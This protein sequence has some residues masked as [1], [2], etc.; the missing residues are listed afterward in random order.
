MEEN[1]IYKGEII[2]QENMGLGIAIINGMTVFVNNGL[3]GDMGD[4]MITSIKKNYAIGKMIDFDKKSLDRVNPICNNFNVC[5][6]CDLMHQ[7]YKSQLLFKQT[8]VIDIIKRIAKLDNIRVNNIIGM[9]DPYNYRNKV[10]YHVNNN[11]GFYKKETNDIVD[12]EQCYLV[13]ELINKSYLLIKK[14]LI[15]N[16]INV[17]KIMFRLGVNTKELMIVFYGKYNKKQYELLNEYIIKNIKEITTILV[18]DNNK[19]YI[20][21]GDGYITEIIMGLSFKIS[22][23]SFFQVNSKQVEKLYNIVKNNIDDKDKLIFDLYSG[24]GTIG[25]IVNNNINK[26]IGIEIVEDAVNDAL[27]NAKINNIDNIEFINGDVNVKALELYKN[28]LKPDLI[29]IDPPRKG[30]DTKLLETII[31]LKPK[32]IIYISCDPVTLAR[33]LKILSDIYKV[34]E[35]T[36]VDMFPNTYHVECVCKLVRK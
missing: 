27:E 32:K 1:K 33:D 8:K 21:Y 4:I 23:D 24:T 7:D 28:N 9:D 25:L 3:P 16:K 30:C 36:P 5:G 12:V 6:G 13:D 26:V 20:L 31:N 14:Y 35:I 19:Q 17:S 18:E 34:E 22:V 10:V 11:I 2:R 29:I 15:N